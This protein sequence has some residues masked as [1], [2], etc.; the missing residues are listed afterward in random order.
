[1]LD[2]FSFRGKLKKTNKKLT[3]MAEFQV[4]ETMQ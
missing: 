4:E 1:L 3:L 2:F